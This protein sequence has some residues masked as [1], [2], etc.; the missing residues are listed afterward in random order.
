MNRNFREVFKNLL[1]FGAARRWWRDR[2]EC[3][4][5]LGVR[6]PELSMGCV[7]L[8]VGLGWV[9]SKFSAVW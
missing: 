8:Q 5:R 4:T 1:R 7:N 6:L 3:V 2:R 9:G